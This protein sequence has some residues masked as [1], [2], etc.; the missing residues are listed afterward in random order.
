MMTLAHST[1]I[2]VQIVVDDDTGNVAALIMA[3]TVLVNMLVKLGQ[4]IN[5]LALWVS[6]FA[7]A[8][9]FTYTVF[10]IGLKSF[11]YGFT[12]VSL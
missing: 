3:L 4:F 11:T 12:G 5:E 6:D 2:A 8:V 1:R 10:T 9:R 7:E